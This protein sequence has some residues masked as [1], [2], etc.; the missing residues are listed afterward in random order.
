MFLNSS[1]LSWNDLIT[2]LSKEAFKRLVSS[3]SLHDTHVCSSI[4]DCS[5]LYWVHLTHL[6]WFIHRSPW[7]GGVYCL[8][9]QQLFPP[10]KFSPVLFVQKIIASLFLCY[11]FYKEYIFSELSSR[12]SPPLRRGG[13]VHIHLSQSSSPTSDLIAMLNLICIYW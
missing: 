1:D 4:K 12:V 8:S 13:G 10:H 5:P 7:T 2:P 6:E 11:W 9:S 3:Q